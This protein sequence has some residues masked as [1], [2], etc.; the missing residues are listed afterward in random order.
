M[1]SETY[2]VDSISKLSE[3]AKKI[4]A[5][6]GEIKV[7]VFEGQ[8]GAGKTTLIKAICREL[9]V[10][11][12][13]SSPTFAIINQYN[14]TLHGPVYHFDCYRLK[15]EK[16]A[17][18]AGCEE[19]LYSGNYCFIEWPEIIYN[20]LPEHYVKVG[21][22]AEPDESRTITLSKTSGK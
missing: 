15:N 6:S 16:E 8:M 11:E 3:I 21:V 13:T 9:G 19:Y 12:E 14:S 20:L 7:I 18:D 17:F 4:L 5:F 10:K 22:V 2:I 1:Q